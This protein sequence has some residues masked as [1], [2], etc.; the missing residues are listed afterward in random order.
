MDD[1]QQELSGKEAYEARKAERMK[2]SSPKRSGAP[3][4]FKH[5]RHWGLAVAVIAVLVYGGYLAVRY[6]APEGED[7]SRAV[8]VQGD[9]H[10]PVGA[11]HEPYN[12]SPP[13]SGPHYAEPARPGFREGETIVDEHLV[14]SLEHGLIWI[15]YRPDVL[16]EIVEALQQF[17][18]GLTVITERSAND[19]DIAL[20]A[21]GRLDT[22]DVGDAFTDA[23]VT[24]V[25]DF[26]KRYANRG[27][28]KIPGGQ[29]GG[30]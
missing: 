13:T 5:A 1:T 3:R 17:D 4:S 26:I 14:H 15:S 27:P 16:P 6:G 24:R 2:I 23:D 10:I 22:F 8:P 28:E 21:W 20:A 30:V 19:S 7:M 18:N 29:H 11:A 9:E 12:S 25:R